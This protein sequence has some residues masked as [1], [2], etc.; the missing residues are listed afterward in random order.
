MFD[1]LDRV[2][3]GIDVAELNGTLTVLA[4]TLSGRGGQIADLAAQADAYLT[5]FEPLLP[6]LRRDLLQVA[7]FAQLGVETSPALIHILENASVTAGTVADEQQALHTL[8]VDLS[9]LGGTAEEF[10]AANGESLTTLLHR[11]RP[12]ASTLRAYS[13]ELPCLLKGLDESRKM[14]AAAIGGTEPGLRALVSIRSELP[15][16]TFPRDLPGFPRG[17]GPACHGLPR[18]VPSQIPIPERGEPQ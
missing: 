16:Y 17:R 12:T 4:R 1:G 2:L 6:Q 11:L 10:L 5:R 18:L 7:R 13:T 14:A 9:I 15:E 8:L 3:S